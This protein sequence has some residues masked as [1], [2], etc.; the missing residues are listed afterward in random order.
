MTLSRL[1]VIVIASLAGLLFG[2]DT[3]VIAGVTQALREAYGLSPAGLGATVSSALWGTLLGALLMGGP[4]DRFGARNVLRFIGLLY[5]VSA[6][7]CA[8]AWSLSSFVVFRFLTGIAIGGSSVLAPVYIAETAPARRRGAL[9]GL[10]QFNIV[11]GILA[12]YLSNYLV[13][14]A[15]DGMTAWRWKLAVAAF[16][17]L[18]FF[19]LLF[20]IPQSARWLVVR[21][22]IA[23]AVTSLRRLG[24]DTPLATVEEF[25]RA[26]EVSDPRPSL[27][28][29]RHRGPI[30]LA[31]TLALFNQLSGINAILYYLGDIFKAAG[32][33]A[34]SAD[35]QSVAIGATNLAATVVAMSIIDKAGRKRLLLSGAV[36]MALALSGVAII[37]K[38]ERGQSFL[39]WMLIVFIASFAV[40]Q[41]AVIWVYLS[42]LFPTAL[43][44]RGQS[45]GSATHWVMNALIAGIFPAVAA[46][47]KAAPFAFFAAMMV[48]QLVV[49]WRWFPETKGIALEDMERKLA[50][51]PDYGSVPSDPGALNAKA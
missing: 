45:L 44:A 8:L 37:M 28:W 48:L 36:G 7:G 46:H 3:A 38:L 39:L 16:P 5:L 9:V 24:D 49:V 50:R 17:A 14:Q 40:S 11:F 29:R 41:G 34:L 47:S 32:F 13:A 2:F 12:A 51:E 25:Q 23:Q 26:S 27:S 19:S 31:V 42:E 18:L 6:I 10:F 20:T 30:V 15:V 1:T 21:G 35:G 4:G 22:R 43:R 33:S